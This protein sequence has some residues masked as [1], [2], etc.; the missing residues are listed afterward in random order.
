MAISILTS[1]VTGVTLTQ[2]CIGG[3]DLVEVR[4]RT[5]KMA[6]NDILNFT[7]CAFWELFAETGYN[8][9][10]LL[11]GG[12]VQGTTT[13]YT[14]PKQ[15]CFSA[16]VV[17]GMGT[18]VQYPMVWQQTNVP[19]R[20]N[21]TRLG[22]CTMQFDISGAP[23]RLEITLRLFFVGKMDFGAP[24]ASQPDN[25]DKLLKVASWAQQDLV[26]QPNQNIYAAQRVISSGCLI[27][28]SLAANL[29]AE[30][31][32]NTANLQR[33]FYNMEWGGGA[34]VAFLT[35]EFIVERGGFTRTT[36]SSV[37]NSLL[38]IRI[39]KAL[40]PPNID[41][42]S[43][44]M[45]RVDRD[46]PLRIW[47]DNY[48]L[49]QVLNTPAV[50]LNTGQHVNYELANTVFIAPATVITPNTAGL[51]ETTVTLNKTAFQNPDGSAKSAIYRF[52]AVWTEAVS[53]ERY[54]FISDEYAV[55]NCPALNAPNITGTI[56][57]YFTLFSNWL[58]VTPLERIRLSVV[59]EAALYN[60]QR[61]RNML[62]AAVRITLSAY[63]EETI[64]VDTYRQYVIRESTI[65]KFNGTWGASPLAGM[66]IV[67]DTFLDTLNANY[68]FRVRN[69]PTV[70][71]DLTV[72]MTT[73]AKLG[74]AQATGSQDWVGKTIIFVWV[75]QMEQLNPQYIDELVYTQKIDVNQ[76]DTS[77]ISL[78]LEDSLGN[79]IQQACVGY[80]NEFTAKW[81]KTDSGDDKL[82]PVVTPDPF[83]ANLTQ[84]FDKIFGNLQQL[85]TPLIND[86]DAN[87]VAN[88][89]ESLVNATQLQTGLLYRLCAIKKKV[90]TV[91][92]GRAL[93]FSG[94]TD[95]APAEYVRA[96][97]NA[98][99]NFGGGDFSIE[100]WVNAADNL[101]NGQSSDVFVTHVDQ[102]GVNA[103]GWRFGRAKTAAGQ[104]SLVF[105]VQQSGGIAKR[106]VSAIPIINGVWNQVVIVK[107]TNTVA[108]WVFYINGV[109]V[110]KAILVDVGVLTNVD[111]GG[112]NP[113]HLGYDSPNDT[114]DSLTGALD[115]VR[116]FARAMTAPEILAN[117]ASGAG[118]C[119]PPSDLTALRA[120]FRL[121][122]A[123]GT[124]A[125]DSSPTANNGALLNYATSRTALG[126]GAWILH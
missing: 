120:R 5:D 109:A 95:P 9:G 106:I 117:Y 100:L 29:Y 126:G 99:Y 114:G 80:Y 73:G 75:L 122:S 79:P 23:A 77:V 67:P 102:T 71:N 32:V 15:P 115:E 104:S 14:K 42:V 45:I 118:Y 19:D 60:S 13:F 113:L 63:Y 108:N 30:G 37:E 78:D 47:T 91:N 27:I 87:F 26:F 110:A 55:S 58:K 116:L 82:I 64:G 28:E 20:T 65:S 49:S 17:S 88:A 85:Q 123:S 61:P 97:F 68:E 8:I 62:D 89:A 52:I 76:Y 10:N 101:N 119:N 6:L 25:Q 48:E 54:A 125:I 69:D 50:T 39:N 74:G 22:R 7:I 96:L 2:Q 111:G 103:N 44:M 57:D 86:S 12:Y 24:M 84:E 121:D 107:S 93:T 18:G 66:T 3:L 35:P 46:D 38:R 53:T 83:T 4:Y 34:P 94:A 72:N 31:R 36:L 105:Q 11:D 70:R 81:S 21:Q 51:N 16:K 59:F 1:T 112:S 40:S 43:I 41:N 33:R 98:A 124:V 90:P 92:C 56:S